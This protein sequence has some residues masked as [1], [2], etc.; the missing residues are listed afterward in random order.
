M[1]WQESFLCVLVTQVDDGY[2]VCFS[3]F[4]PTS[5]VLLLK[6]RI[7]CIFASVY[8][9]SSEG[10]HQPGL[11]SYT[12]YYLIKKSVS[13]CVASHADRHIVKNK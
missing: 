6:P 10:Q 13:S 5:P 4:V 8:P 12:S 3:A 7:L 1:L 9:S 11:T 2:G